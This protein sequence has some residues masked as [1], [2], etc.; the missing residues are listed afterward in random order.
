MKQLLL[1]FLL[2]T[3]ACGNDPGGSPKAV[4][5]HM[6]EDVCS[7]CGMIISNDRFGAQQYREGQSP[8]LFDDLGCLIKESS[9]KNLDHIFVRSFEDSSW[10]LASSA[11]AIVSKEIH[12]PMG[13]GIA[14]FPT[15]KA[16]QTYAARFQGARVHEIE[17]LLENPVKK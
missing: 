10:I 7:A 13:Y 16:A 4:Q 14:A 15:E 2:F 6:G 8:A 9:P 5:L 17:S 12:S 11:F 3:V 1:L